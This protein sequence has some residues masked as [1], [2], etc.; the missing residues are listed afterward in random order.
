MGLD[1]D[2]AKEIMEKYFNLKMNNPAFKSPEYRNLMNIENEIKNMVFKGDE[3][4]PI[5][6]D[7]Q[8]ESLKDPNFE[9]KYNSLIDNLNDILQSKQGGLIDKIRRAMNN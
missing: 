1:E 4:L 2:Y 6:I 5:L 3:I 8:Q 9:S 7:F